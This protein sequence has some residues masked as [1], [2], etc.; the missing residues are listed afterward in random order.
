M[1]VTRVQTGV[2]SGGRWI[3]ASAGMT[4]DRVIFLTFISRWPAQTKYAE[5]CSQAGGNL[6]VAG[7]WRYQPGGFPGPTGMAGAGN[8]R[9]LST[10]PK[11]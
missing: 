8:P 4:D 9:R 10:T 7:F 6:L 2:Q 3:P 1:A 5:A 11:L